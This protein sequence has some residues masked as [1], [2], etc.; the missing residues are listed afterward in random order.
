[1]IYINEINRKHVRDY[2]TSPLVHSKK[3][4]FNNECTTIRSFL[5]SF[6]SIIV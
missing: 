6:S 5:F 3:T 1:M 4:F 2:F